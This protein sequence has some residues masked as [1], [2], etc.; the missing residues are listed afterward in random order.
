[1]CTEFDCQILQQNHKKKKSDLPG[2]K[3]KK[4]E[5]YRK[6]R[7]NSRFNCMNV[8]LCELLM[9]VWLTTLFH[10]KVPAEYAIFMC[11]LSIQLSSAVHFNSFILCFYV[12]NWNANLCIPLITL[13]HFS[14][15]EYGQC[16]YHI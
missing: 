4:P 7:E 10:S 16:T 13:N 9:Q 6:M 8:S 2:S 11:S 5:I 14:L 1:M 3:C 15:A 12:L